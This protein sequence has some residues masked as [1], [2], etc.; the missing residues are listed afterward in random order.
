[1]GSTWL[2]D[3]LEQQRVDRKEGWLV[4]KWVVKRVEKKVGMKEDY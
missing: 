4:E 1:M 3:V 2:G